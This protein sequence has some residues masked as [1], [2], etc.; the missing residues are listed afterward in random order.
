MVQWKEF[1][2]TEIL[3][4]S[5]N[6]FLV[7]TDTCVHVCDLYLRD[8]FMYLCEVLRSDFYEN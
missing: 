6:V 3:D 1:L 4:T 2:N 5:Q 7:A 8:L